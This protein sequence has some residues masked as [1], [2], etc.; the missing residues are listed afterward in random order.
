MATN[1]TFAGSMKISE[2]IE[3]ALLG[4]A[5][6]DALGVPVEFETRESLSRNP[7]KGMLGN[8]FLNQPPGTWSD[9]SSL[10]FCTCESLCNGYNLEDIAVQFSNW[11]NQR[12][13]T[14]HGRVFTIGVQTEKAIKRIDRYIEM[15]LRIKPYSSEGVNEKENGNGSLMR[16]LPLA[17]Y[18]KNFSIEDRY[19][20]ARDVSALTHPHVR[21]VTACFIYLQY[22]IALLNKK[23]KTEAYNEIQHSTLNF[24]QKKTDTKE[25][26]H[27]SRI[28]NES[29]GG[30]PE[31]CIE[32]TPYV[33][34]S[35]EAALWSVM[36]Y[37]NYRDTVSGAVNLGGDTDTIGALAGGL[38]GLLYG[39]KQIPEDWLSVLARKDDIIDL[40]SRFAQNLF[41]YP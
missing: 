12:F 27:Y 40:A 32:S 22:A 24:L 7:V 3:S 34:H 8:L 25:L 1:I 36:R 31:E 38:A 4:F 15:G 6:G 30:F 13:W 41:T 14:P 28:F 35:L 37:D 5:I 23:D 16:I 10:V 33:V 39:K 20:V 26:N 18:L 2:E 11:K 21:A 19:S 29:I 17:F 9:D